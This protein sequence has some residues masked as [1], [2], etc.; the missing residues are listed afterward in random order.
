M[1][2]KATDPSDKLIWIVNEIEKYIID[3][4]FSP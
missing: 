1:C 2:F 4:I 3:K